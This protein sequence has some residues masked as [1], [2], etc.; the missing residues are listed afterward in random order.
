MWYMKYQ[1]Q[2]FIVSVNRFIHCQISQLT[3]SHLAIFGVEAV[4]RLILLLNNPANR[5]VVSYF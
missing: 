4:N 3:I 5:F 1:Y 2:T